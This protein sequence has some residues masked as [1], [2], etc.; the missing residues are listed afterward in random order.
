MYYYETVGHGAVSDGSSM[1]GYNH[2]LHL[3]SHY[4]DRD[5]HD[6]RVLQP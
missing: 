5:A 3:R 2:M 1:E 4:I 6:P